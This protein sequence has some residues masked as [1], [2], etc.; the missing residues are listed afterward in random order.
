[1]IVQGD[2]VVTTLNPR[3]PLDRALR[4]GTV[5]WSVAGRE[6]SLSADVF[7]ETL[8]QLFNR[9]VRVDLLL[10]SGR[11]LLEDPCPSDVLSR[12]G[13]TPVVFGVGPRWLLISKGAQDRAEAV[14]LRTRQVLARSDAGRSDYLSF[15]NQ[16]LA[17]RGV[18][19]VA[20]L[21]LT[22]V[23]FICGENNALRINGRKSSV[24]RYP[25]P[26]LA[27]I[28]GGRWVALN[29]AHRPYW[30]QVKSKG[31]AKVGRTVDGSGPT[32]GRVVG[33]RQPYDDGT[34]PPIAFVHANNFLA[35][36]PGTRRYA[37]VAFGA[38]AAGPPICAEIE[39]DG[40]KVQWCFSA[41]GL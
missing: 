20:D 3:T 36:K 18:I 31:F 27:E 6:L 16:I 22:L 10:A 28:L 5:S 29:P 4:L 14:V 25:G 40:R 41:Y 39:A 37:S 12:T 13:D 7:L 26:G 2:H 30:P 35:D 17:G 8:G 1:M 11:P 34:I 32:M 38:H 9:G 33:L 19:R 24:L 15:T 23:L 21:E